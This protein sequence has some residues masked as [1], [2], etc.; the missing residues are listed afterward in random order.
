MELGPGIP[1]D[2]NIA[3]YL[4][5]WNSGKFL[6]IADWRTDNGATARQWDASG[7]QANMEFDYCYPWVSCS[8]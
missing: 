4:L 7:R 3:E 5:N 2:P 8:W 1:S 6:E